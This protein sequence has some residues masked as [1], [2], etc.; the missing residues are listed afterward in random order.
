MENNFKIIASADGYK[1]F[2]GGK[3]HVNLGGEAGYKDFIFLRAGYQSGFENKNISTGIGLKYKGICLDYA[4]VPHSSS[5]G[6]SNSLS[7]GF[8]F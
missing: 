4:F 1:I 7:I 5:F 6:I 8:S 3:M 2:N